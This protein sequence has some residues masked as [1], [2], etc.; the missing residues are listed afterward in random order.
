[1]TTAERVRELLDWEENPFNVRTDIQPCLIRPFDIDELHKNFFDR[2]FKELVEWAE[3]HPEELE[4][5][6]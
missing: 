4:N 2:K 6:R 1:M 3:Q 5:G